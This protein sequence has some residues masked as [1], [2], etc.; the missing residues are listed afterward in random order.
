M[1]IAASYHR[2]NTSRR[3]PRQ[4]A[5]YPYLLRKRCNDHPNQAGSP[6]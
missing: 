4:K 2:A 6:T 5:I 3:Q 1:G